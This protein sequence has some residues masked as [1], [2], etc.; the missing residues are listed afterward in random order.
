MGIIGVHV[1]FKDVCRVGIL[2]PRVLMP[3]LHLVD[4]AK[5]HQCSTAF[6]FQFRVTASR[7]TE[8]CKVVGRLFEQVNSDGLCCRQIVENF[9]I[10]D[11]SVDGIA[12]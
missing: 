1:A 11:Q 3:F 4:I 12:A 6:K 2:L 9:G 5:T 8:L 7:G 10:L